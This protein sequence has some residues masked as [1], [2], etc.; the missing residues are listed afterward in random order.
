[1]KK[2]QYCRERKKEIL[3]VVGKAWLGIVWIA[4]LVD[5]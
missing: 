4:T 3:H 5:R 1:M 2:R